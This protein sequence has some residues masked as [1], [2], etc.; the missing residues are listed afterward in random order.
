M[1]KFL[2]ILS[3]VVLWPTAASWA[4]L[5]APNEV[6]VTMG[7]VHL[8]VRNLEANKRFWALL[9]GT[10]FKIDG[11]EVMK[12][13]GVFVFLTPGTPPDGGGPPANLQVICGC[14]SDGFEPG[15]INHLGFLVRDF[16]DYMARFKAADLKMKEIGRASCRERV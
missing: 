9:G 14:P 15:V 7:H 10:P 4:Q 6:G 12:F 8:N 11:T 3:L 2:V 16:D 1:K 5:L 13:P